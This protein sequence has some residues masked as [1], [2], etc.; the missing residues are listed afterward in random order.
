MTKMEYLQTVKQEKRNV[1]VKLK[2]TFDLVVSVV[3]LLL[4]FPILLV[5]SILLLVFSGRP[6]F[7][8]QVRVGRHNQPFVIW[9]FRTMETIKG[10]D[11]VHQ[12]DWTGEV[13]NNFVFK[14]PS[15]QK[16]TNIGKIYRKLSIDE[17]PQLLNVIK[18][19]MSLVGPRPEIPEITK[20]YDEHQ[21]R[22]LNVKPGITGHAQVNGRSIMSHGE[23]IEYDLHYVRHQSLAFDLKIIWRT[24]GQV[25]RGKGAC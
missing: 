1:D 16:I 8:K 10:K 14:T 20:F 17:L 13:P 7:F 4:L 24:I 5:F 21:I 6:I 15:S 18:G 9:K 3:L 19:D 2:R 22:R 25:I 23:K 12:Y 11:D